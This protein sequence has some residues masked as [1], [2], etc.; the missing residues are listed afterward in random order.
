[1]AAITAGSSVGVIGSGAMGSGIAQVAA[2]AGRHAVD[3]ANDRHGQITQSQHQRRV[4][5]FDGC[6]EVHA[7]RARFDGAVG[8]VLAGA[9]AA[10]G[11]GANLAL[12]YTKK[13][14]QI[15]HA[16]TLPEQLKL[17]G[18][19]MRELGYSHDYKEGVAAFIAKRTPE[20]KGE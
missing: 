16:N 15:S 19:M 1:M 6:A 13:A 8:Q 2:A 5:F 12:A 17:E 3:G 20:F 11:A 10:A 7:L 4:K 14:L 9:E 18:E